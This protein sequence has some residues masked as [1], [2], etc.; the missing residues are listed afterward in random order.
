[1][2]RCPPPVWFEHNIF[3]NITNFDFKFAKNSVHNVQINLEMMPA[4]LHTISD[5]ISAFF[6]TTIQPLTAEQLQQ[7]TISLFL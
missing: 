4:L 7:L 2:R 6:N 3:A 5:K 1:M